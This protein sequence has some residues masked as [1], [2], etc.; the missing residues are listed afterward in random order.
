M[1]SCLDNIVGVRGC[2]TGESDFY[3]NDLTGINIP[4][5]D[6][7]LNPEK[8][9]AAAAFATIISSGIKIVEADV[10]A[11][12]KS[13]YELKTFIDNDV[14]GYYYGD[15]E[16][17]AAETGYL[18]GYEIRIDKLDYVR[19]FISGLKLFVPYTGNVP[20]YIYD[21]MQDK[22]LNTVNVS[23]V[24]GQIVDVG[25][26]DL[27]YLSKKQRLHLFI[28]YQSD[29]ASYKTSYLSPYNGVP[30]SQDCPDITCGLYR[31][32]YVYFRS[33]K[34]LANAQKIGANVEGNSYG[35]GISMFYSLQCDFT[36]VLCNARNLLGLALWYK[37]GEL[38]MKEL[39]RSKRLTG[40]V[41]VYKQDHAELE[42]EYR[43]DYERA[44]E[45]VLLNMRLPE[46]ICF[47]CSPQI[48]SRV[49]LP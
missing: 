2:G 22:L 1:A 41:T 32:H 7:A 14:I 13:K 39:R 30:E 12:L 43:A 15:K 35:A 19:F 49:N 20:I 10:N 23:V 34:I 24:S 25:E 16:T 36:Q 17:V 33:A 42:A 26:I 45:N 44:F 11:R 9:N 6:K 27:S 31:N 28:G 3:V 18:T 48:Y 29:F 37:A 8:T 40:V 21:L 38:I 4:D 5:F 46:S 47:S